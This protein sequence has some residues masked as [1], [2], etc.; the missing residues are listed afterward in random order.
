MAHHAT[1]T[2]LALSNLNKDLKKKTDSFQNRELISRKILMME[3]DSTV[4]FKAPS[5]PIPKVHVSLEDDAPVINA[6]LVDKTAAAIM[7]DEGPHSPCE[8]EG[9]MSIVHP[10]LHYTP[11]PWA[12][13]PEPGLGYKLEVVKNGTIVGCFDLDIRKHST[14]IVIG[15]LPNCD[16]VLDHPSISRYHCILQYGD[17][18]MDRSGKGWHMYDMGS[19]HGS[20]ANKKK[21]P[22]KQYMR[23]MVGFVLQFGGS[24]R[25][26]SLL[27]PSTDCEAEWECSPS[28]MRE[29]MHKKI[30]ESK[31]A[32]AAK[33]E[34]EEEKAKEA[35]SSDGID[36][37]MGFDE[38]TTPGIELEMDDHLMED[39]EQYY[40]AD[41]KKALAKFFEREG[42]DMNFQ[43]TEQGSGHTHKWLC[44][45]ELPIEING[46]DRTYTAQAIVSTS[47]KDAQVQCALEACRILDSYGVLRSSNSKARMKRKELEENDFYDEDDDE[48]LDRTG[49]I[50]KQREKRMMWAKNKSGEKT[51]K[52]STYESLCKELEETRENIAK[53]KAKLDEIHAAHTST[54]TGDSLDD[55]CRQLNEGH[56]VVLDMKAK[57]E[58][59]QLRQKLVALTHDAQRLEK[60]VKIAKPVALPELKVAGTNT[61]GVD[62]QAF[63]RK[64]MMV[65]RKKAT[66]TKS[67]AEEGTSM[68]G[69]AGMPSSSEVF[70]PEVEA[71]DE[72]DEHVPVPSTAADVKTQQPAKDN[73]SESKRLLESSET[74][75]PSSHEMSRKIGKE[76]RSKKQS[77]EEEM[78]PQPAPVAFRTDEQISE[79]ISSISSSPASEKRSSNEEKVE[80]SPLLSD[81]LEQSALGEKSPGSAQRAEKRSLSGEGDTSETTKKKRRVRVRVNRTSVDASDAY[82]AGVDDD[83]YATWLPPDNQSGD[84]KTAL[85][86]KFEGRY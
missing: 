44:T 31:L 2:K 7:P 75:Q 23:I 69:P 8:S 84:G 27:G 56:G 43:L 65:G 24:T 6:E 64:M 39:R 53:L 72:V 15:R 3:A 13:V 32:A 79:E 34:L 10:E 21:V 76:P 73:E 5:L 37:G 57:T 9:K 40:Q 60:L 47:K 62:K 36:W 67:A 16:V 22:A 35:E 1:A 71:D 45:I 66:E 55:Y 14:F 77:C 83:R 19:T 61:S 30:L 17:D 86:A 74:N 46:V 81:T 85:N 78:E 51:E 33:R 20:K 28:E 38:D 48:Y 12:A 54:N 26:L 41:P 80:G 11:P 50:E 70:K 52:K 63:L 58:T 25:L 68:K 18:P 82:G 4:P 49:Q 29:K 42:F 59:S